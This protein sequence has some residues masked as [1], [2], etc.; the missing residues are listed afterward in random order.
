MTQVPYLKGELLLRLLEDTVGRDRFDR[1][2]RGYF[3]HFAF[4]SITTSD[5]VAYLQEQLLTG[6]EA[7]VVDALQLDTWLE[8]PGLPA[9]AP[10]SESDALTRVA[11][12]ADSWARGEVAAAALDTAAWTTQ[13]WL[14]F[15]TSVPDSL[16]AGQ[17]QELDTAFGLTEAGNSEV[18][19]LW[20]LTAI[21]NQYAPAY[22]RLE[23]YLIEIGR[24][25]LI[26]PLYDE[27]VK[28]ADGRARAQSI[29]ERAR[30]GYHPISASSIDE[31][32]G[33]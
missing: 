8:Q 11:E 2:L 9:N 13:E 3:D 1:F 7:G 16:T 22:P 28:T 12:R 10:R 20:L 21:R 25:K 5:F 26:K 17:M 30:P 24:R 18:A 4:R 32:L 15:L 27:L 6:V 14:H 23:S 31:V 19:H 33:S 29:Y